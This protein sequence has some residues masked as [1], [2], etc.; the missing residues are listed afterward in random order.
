MAI[1][2]LKLIEPLQNKDKV[3]EDE[4]SPR[5]V[6]DALRKRAK[7]LGAEDFI[8]VAEDVELSNKV[9]R[10]TGVQSPVSG[11][12]SVPSSNKGGGIITRWRKHRRS[13]QNCLRRLTRWAKRLTLVRCVVIDDFEHLGNSAEGRE[14][15]ENAKKSPV[16]ETEETKTHVQYEEE[17]TEQ[18]LSANKDLECAVESDEMGNTHDLDPELQVMGKSLNQTS[19]GD[20]VKKEEVAKPLP[21]EVEKTKVTTNTWGM[22]SQKR[23]LREKMEDLSRGSS[24]IGDGDS[25]SAQESP[26]NIGKEG[27]EVV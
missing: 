18:V 16:V 4:C 25:S 11:A 15:M 10:I 20:L 26:S 5:V 2:K 21:N 7:V 8:D 9:S 23:A 19:E 14:L 13:Y 17:V 24:S 27:S 6:I 1:G 3:L 22:A 12:E